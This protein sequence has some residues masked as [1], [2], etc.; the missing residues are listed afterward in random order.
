M[1]GFRTIY[2]HTLPN[3][4]ESD[5]ETLETHAAAVSDL[6]ESFAAA[7]GAAEWGRLLGRWHDLGK[8]SDEFQS[9]LHRTSD[10]DAAENEDVLA[11]CE[12][13]FTEGQFT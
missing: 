4:P 9:Y 3:R 13:W 5:W 7:F 6:A 1:S 12:V 2:A 11:G 8:R 10:P